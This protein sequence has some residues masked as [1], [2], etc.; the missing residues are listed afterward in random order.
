MSSLQ[1]VLPNG[2]MPAS[3]IA[4]E[5]DPWFSQNP[6]TYPAGP[7]GERNGNLVVHHMV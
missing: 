4:A 1:A 5:P 6:V 2:H 7:Q 3:F